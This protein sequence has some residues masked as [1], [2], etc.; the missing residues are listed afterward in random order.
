MARHYYPGAR[1]T[2]EDSNKIELSWLKS[3]GFLVGFKGGNIQWSRNGEP[4]GNINIQVDTYSESPNI[5]F[6]YKVRPHG[7]TEEWQNIS[8]SFRLESLP[9]RFGGKKWFFVCELY[10][11]GVY[12]GQKVRVL[13]MV[14]NYFGCRRCANLSYDSCNQNKR[15]N[16]GI[17]KA[18][19]NESKAEE[20]YLKN[21]KRL[22][23]K[24]KP[25]KKYKRYL[26]ISDD[27]SERDLYE[28]HNELLS[29]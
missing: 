28:I 8:F 17:W 27:L 7:S 22:F 6:D 13:Y 4:T 25:T 26:K 19:M 24:G 12:C 21:V 11:K 9:C 29:K 3:K 10:A 20:Y 14:G 16:H 18:F 1:Y 23:Y 2:V 5:K 15:F